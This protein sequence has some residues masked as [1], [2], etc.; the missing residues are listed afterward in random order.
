VYGEKLKLDEWF[1]CAVWCRY[2]DRREEPERVQGFG[3]RVFLAVGT[4]EA[5]EM[6]EGEGPPDFNE[7]QRW[8]QTET[9]FCTGSSFWGHCGRERILSS[10]SSS[11]Q[12]PHEVLTITNIN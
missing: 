11:T 2:G 8:N 9:W 3:A 4:Q 6:C 10:S 7:A 5:A 12:S 1:C